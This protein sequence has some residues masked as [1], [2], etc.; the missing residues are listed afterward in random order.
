MFLSTYKTKRCH[1]AEL[2][3]WY[4]ETNLHRFIIFYSYSFTFVIQEKKNKM[5]YNSLYSGC[6]VPFL[7]CSI[8]YVDLKQRPV[9]IRVFIACFDKQKR[10]RCW[11]C[12]NMA[13]FIVV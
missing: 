4:I 2:C 9:A 11:H 7:L 13:S 3:N 6:V 5:K 8:F 1:I 10:C 12:C